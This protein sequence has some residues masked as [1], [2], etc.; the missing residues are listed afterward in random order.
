MTDYDNQEK[1]ADIA[2]LKEMN[3]LR[4]IIENNSDWIWEV[5]ATGSY[6]FSSARSIELLGR[7]PHEVIGKTPFDFMPAEEAHRVGEIVAKIAAARLPF[8]GLQNR[9]IRADG[10]EILVETSAIPLFDEQGNFKGYRGIDRNLSE[11][12]CHAGK[13]LFELE[14]IYS[15]APAGLCF[16]DSALS[17]VTV[18]DYLAELLGKNTAEINGRKVADFLPG[19]IPILQN[20]LLMAY[21][22]ES[23]PDAEFQ[24]PDKARVFFMRINAAK[25]PNGQVSGLSVAMIDISPLKEMQEKLRSSQQHYRNMVE[26]NPQIPWTASPDGM[27]TD[28]SSRFEKITGLTREE[29]LAD[30]WLRT[31][32]TDDRHPTLVSWEHSLQTQEPLDVEIRFCHVEK[33]WNW[34]RIRAVPSVDAQG[35][36]LCWYGTVE[37]IHERKLLELKLIKANRRLEIQASTD[38]LTKLPNRREFKKVL[39]H[40]FMRAKRSS[41]PLAILMI[42]IDYFK[43]F[44]DYY[45]HISGDACL[46]LVARALRK[47]LK[48]NTDIVARYGGEEFAAILPDTDPTGASL[49]A[50]HILQSIRAMGIKHYDSKFRKVT[51]SLGVTVYQAPLHPGISDQADLMLAADQALYYSKKNGRNQ[52]NVAELAR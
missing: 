40:E 15:N 51:I 43:N 39:A 5:D 41:S 50:E 6:I 12:P 20:A 17:Y 31:I 14:S 11:L 49:V 8:T 19:I 33:G 47:A 22:N 16:I 34:M 10:S 21:C 36:V 42:D 48:R 23:I 24:M 27:I 35:Q 13:R 52:F 25:Y 37:D 18:N 32:H 45:G 30:K 44:N 29:A 28:V 3:N 26:L 2:L 4:D 9:N 7:L 46:R 1:S 38:S